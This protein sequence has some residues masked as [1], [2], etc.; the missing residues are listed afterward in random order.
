MLMQTVSCEIQF[1]ECFEYYR[2]VLEKNKL[3]NILN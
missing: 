2:T 1:R 3:Q